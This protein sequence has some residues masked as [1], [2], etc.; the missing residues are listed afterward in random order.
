MEEKNKNILAKDIILEK[1]PGHK[2]S[3]VSSCRYSQDCGTKF[4][5]GSSD[6]SVRLWDLRVGGSVKMFSS[7]KID[8]EISSIDFYE[9]G[10][11]LY[12]SSL[13]GVT[14]LILDMIRFTV[15]MNGTARL[16]ARRPRT[17]ISTRMKMMR[18]QKFVLTKRPEIYFLLMIRNKNFKI[19]AARFR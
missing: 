6:Q 7:P 12:C 9:K 16:F 14:I 18:F 5:T 11:L 2:D 13:N 4:F 19:L 15:L 17:S 1:R 10:G 3:V 8:D